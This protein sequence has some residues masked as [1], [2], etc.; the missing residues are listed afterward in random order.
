MLTLLYLAR[1]TRTNTR[2]V[3]AASTR[4]SSW[5]FADFNA[6]LA[7]D[8]ALASL[9]QK[10]M[11]SDLAT[12]EDLEWL[13]FQL[14]ARSEVGRIQDA[15]LQ[16]RLGFQDQELADS[17]LDFM[18]S[19]LQFPVWR[20][21]WDDEGGTWTKSFVEDV[22]SRKAMHIGMSKLDDLK[23]DSSDS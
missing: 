10:S 6:Q 19:L 8:D 18:R 23:R 13:R 3:V 16:S 20:K 7:S 22:E 1:E 2:A 12:F 14:L 11:D 9:L 21:F 4:A 17:Q 15:Y 5:G